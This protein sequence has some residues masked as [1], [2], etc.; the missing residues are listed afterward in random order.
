[1]DPQ[2]PPMVNAAP[3]FGGFA[4]QFINDILKSSLAQ[5]DQRTLHLNR[6]NWEMANNAMV[7]T[8]FLANAFGLAEDQKK[9]LM[10]F[11]DQRGN[12]VNFV[13]AA[14]GSP[15]PAMEMSPDE[16]DGSS[17]V[18]PPSTAP[19]KPGSGKKKLPS[20]MK[21]MAPWLIGGLLGTGAMGAGALINQYLHKDPPPVAEQPSEPPVIPP[22]A[23]LP[24]D[25][26]LEVE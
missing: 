21:N 4:M 19:A 24:G 17:P 11:P 15:E 23:P 10:P 16:D 8:Q 7:N 12:N 14:L 2:T 22:V 25:V 26:G 5:L 20:L 3:T 9:P 6:H 1:M 18:V 13:Q